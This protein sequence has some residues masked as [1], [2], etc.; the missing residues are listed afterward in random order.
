MKNQLENYLGGFVGLAVGDALGAP[1]EFQKRGSYGLVTDFQKGGPFNLEKG[2]WTD[3]TI[4]SLILSESLNRYK[5]FN[6]EDIMNQ[7]YR[8]WK[9]GYMSPTGIC[10]DIGRTTEKAMNR[11]Q[12]ENVIYAGNEADP[13]S[14]G[15]IMRLLPISLFFSSSLKTS[16]EH[17][18]DMTRLT[19]GPLEC[20]EASVILNYILLMILDGKSKSEIF[21]FTHLE[22]AFKTRIKNLLTNEFL[23]KS[24]EEVSGIG[25]AYETLESAM[26]IFYHANNF[27]D[28]LIKAVNIGDDTDTVGAVYGQMA[29]AYFGLQSIPTQFTEQLYNIAKIKKEA[30]ALW[31]NKK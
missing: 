18:I 17:S 13:P 19:H 27:Y 23:K 2:M 5:T 29:G 6:A 30:E 10:F 11:F 4:L 12:K 20:V 28:G 14:N 9:D 24:Y 26:H 25:N 21:K 1:V 3:D 7:F 15:A 31:Q 16:Q 8:W 22:Y